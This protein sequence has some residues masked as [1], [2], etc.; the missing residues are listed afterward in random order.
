MTHFQAN[1]PQEAQQ[2]LGK[3]ADFLVFISRQ[4]YEQINIGIGVQFAPAIA[5]DRDEGHVDGWFE[6]IS[7]VAPCEMEQLIDQPGVMAN[8]VL[9]G[10]AAVMKFLEA[11]A[12][13]NKGLAKKR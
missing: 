7:E 9:S 2:G 4:Q 8:D 10:S 6:Q 1:V 12:C 3:W 11:V 13:A 5:S